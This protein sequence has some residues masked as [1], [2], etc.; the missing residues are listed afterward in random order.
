[1]ATWF[2]APA[3]WAETERG[4]SLTTT[5]GSD[6]WRKTHYGFVRDNG[7]FL[8]TDVAGDFAAEVEVAGAYRT[9]YDQ[10]GLMVRVNASTWMKCGIEFVDGRQHASVVVT[11]DY[12]DWSI[13]PLDD[14]PPTT[15]FRVVRRGDTLEVSWARPAAPWTALRVAHLPMGETVLV[16][17]MAASPEDRGFAVTFTGFRVEQ[18]G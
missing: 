3:V 5:P 4:L 13:C 8:G 17:P 9:L 16:G 12:S 18:P 6:F 1:M 11:R 15:R 10:A 2:N 14:V 7:H